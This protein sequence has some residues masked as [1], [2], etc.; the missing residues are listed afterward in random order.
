MARHACRLDLLS[1]VAVCLIYSHPHSQASQRVQTATDIDVRPAEQSTQQGAAIN[2]LN[3]LI[4]VMI[5]RARCVPDPTVK[6]GKQRS[7][8]AL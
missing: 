4:A 3:P 5:E 2:S 1:L 6:G 7:E 8:I